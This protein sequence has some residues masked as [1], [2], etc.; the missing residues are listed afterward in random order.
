[1]KCK[2][3]MTAD[4]VCCTPNDSAADIAQ[5]MKAQD[6]GSVP[7]CEDGQ[8]KKLLGIVTDRD[9][10]LKIVAEGRDP[11]TTIAESVMTEDPVTCKPDDNVEIALE[12]MEQHQVRRVPVVDKNG[13]LV[14]II[15]QADVAIRCDPEKTA[16]LV[17]EI[18]RPGLAA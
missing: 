15:A 4:P 7:I 14:G 2:E 8:S 10:A 5:L 6:I 12:A 1:M 18:S 16:E 17:E 9:L 11:N 3:M 13:H